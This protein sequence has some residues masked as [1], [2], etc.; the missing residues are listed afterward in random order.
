LRKHG[1][2]TALRLISNNSNNYVL[3]LRIA[4]R[5]PGPGPNVT[6]R[7]CPGTGPRK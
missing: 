1:S 5:E 7:G 6:L 4:A 2:L 3:F